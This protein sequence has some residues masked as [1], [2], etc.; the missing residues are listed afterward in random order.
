MSVG[1]RPLE[2]THVSDLLT[3]DSR[4]QLKNSSSL[5]FIALF[6]PVRLS[7]STLGEQTSPQFAYAVDDHVDWLGLDKLV[8]RQQKHRAAHT[9]VTPFIGG[10][11][12]VRTLLPARC[13]MRRGRNFTAIVS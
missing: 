1:I 11:R 7:Y 13:S 5:L 4:E 2:T 6:Q 3:R 12:V 9:P 10:G 8:Q